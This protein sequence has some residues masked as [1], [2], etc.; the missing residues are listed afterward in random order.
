MKIKIKF[1]LGVLVCLFG[2]FAS[3]GIAQ[4]TNLAPNSATNHPPG[5]NGYWTTCHNAQ[6]KQW[7]R[8]FVPT[9][10]SVNP[11][12]NRQ[13]QSAQPTVLSPASAKTALPLPTTQTQA[14]RYANSSAT[15]SATRTSQASN[16]NQSAWPVEHRQRT[17][18]VRQDIETSTGGGFW[19]YGRPSARYRISIETTD[20]VIQSSAQTYPPY[21]QVGFGGRG[22][23]W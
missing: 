2:V 14:V 10:S 15:G 18:T 8:C 13:T 5:Q 9:G 20:V 16:T 11:T 4:T 22:W 1:L 23:W 19:G 12:V 17:R 6:T 3:T 21:V 7:F